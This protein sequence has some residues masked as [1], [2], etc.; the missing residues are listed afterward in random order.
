VRCEKS[1]GTKQGARDIWLTGCTT[2][3]L[4]LRLTFEKPFQQPYTDASL[5]FSASDFLSQAERIM[6]R[7]LRQFFTSSEEKSSAI[8]W[9]DGAD[10]KDYE[11]A[12]V[13]RV[14]NLERPNRYPQAIVKVQKESDIVDA[15][16]LAAEKKCCVCVRAGG[17]SWPVWS[18][19]DG[20]ILVDMGN[21]H[22]I[23]LDEKTGIA[24]VSPSTTGLDLNIYLYPRG[25]MFSAGHCPDVGVGGAL[26]CGGMGWNCNVRHPLLSNDQKET[27]GR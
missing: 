12:R 21:Y 23:T 25:R 4:L 22:E 17:H 20:A 7:S 3:T 13:E 14:F 27:D 16:K 6:L 2:T 15:V 26:L 24:R 10:P 5:P 9:R 18:V 11:R 19:R 1:L 8:I